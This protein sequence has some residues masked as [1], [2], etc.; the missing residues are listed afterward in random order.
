MTFNTVLICKTF[1]VNDDD[2]DDSHNND[3]D[4]IK[5]VIMVDNTEGTKTS[6]SNP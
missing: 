4:R 5:M 1:N 3:D 6:Q 2:N